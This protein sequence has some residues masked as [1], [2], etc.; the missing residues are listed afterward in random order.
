MCTS[1]ALD[2]NSTTGWE[3]TP[4]GRRRRDVTDDLAWLLITN[5]QAE[6]LSVGQDNL[7]ETPSAALSQGKRIKRDISD[8][9][10][11]YIGL[12]FD[13]Y[14]DFKNLSD[15]NSSVA[16]RLAEKFKIVDAPELTTLG[17]EILTIEPRSKKPISIQVTC[18]FY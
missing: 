4:I 17:D 3:V 7:V 15:S 13:G 6:T 5:H 12:I 16:Q 8:D 1:P 9:F 10:T 2:V 14:D 11:L 18:A